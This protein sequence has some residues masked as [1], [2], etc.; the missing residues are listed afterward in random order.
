MLWKAFFK[1]HANTIEGEFTLQKDGVKIFDRLLARSGQEGYTDTSW[2]T[3]KSPIP[4][5]VHNLYLD[6]YQDRQRAGAKGIGEFFP[7]A[8]TS[9]SE[10]RAL[11]YK[12]TGLVRKAIGLHEENMWKGSAGCIVIVSPDDWLTL[13]AKLKEIGKSQ[14]SITIEV[15]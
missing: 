1:R 10:I 12:T 11:S 4:F 5:G 6:P 8:N 3:G 13:S 9:T 14:K 15:L 2:R 7:I